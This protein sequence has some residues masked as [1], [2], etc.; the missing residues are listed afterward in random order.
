M[1]EK[2]TIHRENGQDTLLNEL[3]KKQSSPWKRAG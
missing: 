2:K 3:K 1:R